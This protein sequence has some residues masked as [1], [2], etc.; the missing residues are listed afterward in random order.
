MTQ[1]NRTLGR[2][3]EERAAAHVEER[4]YQIVARNYRTPFGELDLIIEQADVLAFVEV[5]TRSSLKFGQPEAAVTSK[6]Q[7]HL[8]EAAQY[9]L[10]ENQWEERLWR[11]DVI[12]ILRNPTT[13]ETEITWFENALV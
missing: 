3:G 6:K 4:G 10:Q 9:F 8:V 1:H 11:I 2:W 5:K 12:S 13:R 7:A